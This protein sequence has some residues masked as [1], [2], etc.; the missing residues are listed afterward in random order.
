MAETTAAEGFPFFG[1]AD[2]SGDVFGSLLGVYEQQ[3]FRRGYRAAI[4]DLLASVVLTT[5]DFLETCAAR[6]PN[7]AMEPANLRHLLYQFGQHLEHHLQA[8]VSETSDET[9][10]PGDGLGI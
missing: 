3:G 9:T 4:R 10:P 1:Q 6:S 8:R 7:A 2:S 5:E